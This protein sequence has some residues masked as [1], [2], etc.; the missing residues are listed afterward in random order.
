MKRVS[1]L[2]S[3]GA[4]LT[5][6]ALKF[7][8]NSAIFWVMVAALSIFAGRS[9]RDFLIKWNKQ[10]AQPRAWSVHT[11]WRDIQD[12]EQPDWVGPGDRT[13]RRKPTNLLIA[14][15]DMRRALTVTAPWGFFQ[16]EGWT[17]LTE[18]SESGTKCNE[19]AKDFVMYPLPSSFSAFNLARVDP[20]RA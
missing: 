20:S 15:S 4:A 1:I 5:C 13:Q 3:E 16:S 9:R 18:Q 7:C 17:W 2:H 14:S 6:F 12:C 10:A 19:R 8:K 11:I